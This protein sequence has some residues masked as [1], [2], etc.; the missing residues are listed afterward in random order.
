MH[1]SITPDKSFNKL[2]Y[3]YTAFR[4]RAQWKL[5]D[6]FPILSQ[7]ILPYKEF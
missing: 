5:H 4:E 2:T 1:N 3:F 7:A 6:N